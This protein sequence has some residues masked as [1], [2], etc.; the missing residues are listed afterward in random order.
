MDEIGN[1]QEVP[2][3]AHIDD[4]LELVIE[5]LAVGIGHMGALVFGHAGL[6]NP[7]FQAFLQPRLGLALQFL[8]LA[9]AFA[10]IIGRQD[11]RPGLD[12]EGRPLGDDQGVFDGFRQVGE[13]RPHFVGR[14]E[15]VVRS[16]PASIGGRKIGPL[17]DADQGVVGFVHGGV[18]KEGF[19]GGH[20][21]QV[22]VVS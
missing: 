19:V 3:I 15:A 13:K 17:S 6:E 12:H 10:A 1:D 7:G 2:R 9:P 21:R 5:A 14:F 8:F 16:Q 20:Q 4:D 22:H 11:G 18:G